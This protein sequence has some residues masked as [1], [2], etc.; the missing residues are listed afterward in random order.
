MVDGDLM[1]VPPRR[2]VLPSHAAIP[3]TKL[4]SNQEGRADAAM[5]SPGG[6]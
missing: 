5:L 1:V 6:H 2:D 4:I 3:L